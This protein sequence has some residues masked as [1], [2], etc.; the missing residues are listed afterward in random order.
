[1]DTAYQVGIAGMGMYPLKLY[2]D[3]N[4]SREGV[5]ALKQ[6]RKPDFRKHTK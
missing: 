6:K 3:T 4:V 2:Y 1:L 5:S